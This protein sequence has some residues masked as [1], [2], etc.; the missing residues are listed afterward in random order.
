MADSDQ[1]MKDV[2]HTHESSPQSVWVRGEVQEEYFYKQHF[3]IY[4][5]QI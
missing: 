4:Q 3:D 1:S 2:S 5:T